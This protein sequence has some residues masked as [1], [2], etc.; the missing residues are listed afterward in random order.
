MRKT[1]VSVLLLRPLF[2]AAE[3][4]PGQAVD[5]LYKATRTHPELIADRDA[6]VSS[7]QLSAGWKALVRLSGRPDIALAVAAA[8]PVG[9]F[10]L[11]EYLCRCAPTVR[12]ALERWVRYLNLLN[13][14]VEVG[15]SEYGDEI[16][17][18]VTEECSTPPSQAHEL[19]FALVA[20]QCRELTGGRCTPR[21]VEFYH[22]APQDPTPYRLYFGCPVRFSARHHRLVMLRASLSAPL[23]TADPQLL[24]LL[25]GHAEEL[26]ARD[27]APPSVT[28]QVRRI[29]VA[30]L[31]DGDLEIAA[32]A[33]LL[34]LTARSLQRRLKT[35]GTFFQSLRDDVRRELAT[36]Y[37]AGGQL[38]LAEIAFLL[39]F[40]EPSAFFR[41]HKRWTGRTPSGVRATM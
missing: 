6:R 8:T 40:S 39:G 25:E 3:S 9:A 38:A 33:S 7:A 16:A 20:S 30:H 22:E 41:A 31:R 34:G 32:V 15:L 23:A 4:L 13:A 5:A 18:E 28:E 2:A 35:E 10:G 12:D 36:R 19:C 14:E 24:A 26:G 11:I 1:S 21:R 37:I 27:P 29:L 17:I